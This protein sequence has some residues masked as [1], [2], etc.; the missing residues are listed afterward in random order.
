MS[1]DIDPAGFGSGRIGSLTVLYDEG[2]PI[3]RTA[4]RWLESRAQLV[5]LRFVPAGS[6]TARECF[7]GL[8]HSATLRDL[9]VIADNG[10]VYVSDGAW[11][12]CLW[13]LADYRGVA[14][15]LSTPSLLPAARRF[16]AA[17]SA[18]RQST[19]AEDYGDV[20]DDSCR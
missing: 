6:E 3:C 9:T 18:V 14:E 16:I 1:A 2:C 17:A 11:L 20:C 19:R 10:L 15:R 8:D 12:A 5:P 13:A 7:P 4:H